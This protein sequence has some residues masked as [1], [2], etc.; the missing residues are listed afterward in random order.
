[1]KKKLQRES[2]VDNQ[3]TI[4]CF[5]NEKAKKSNKIQ[6]KKN[7]KN[8][9]VKSSSLTNTHFSVFKMKK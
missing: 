1:M 6:E 2:I 4:K 9:N 3:H 8:C 7:E 5:Q